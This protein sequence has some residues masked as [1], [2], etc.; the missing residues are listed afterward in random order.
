MG[1]TRTDA[2]AEAPGVKP[3][4][5]TPFTAEHRPTRLHEMLRP[6]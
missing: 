5:R 1:P 2:G 4:L 6:M 3:F